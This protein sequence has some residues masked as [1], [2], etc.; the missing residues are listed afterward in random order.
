[1][2]NENDDV[3]TRAAVL[4]SCYDFRESR[5]ELENHGITNIYR[6]LPRI[7]QPALHIAWH[8]RLGFRQVYAI[9]RVDSETWRRLGRITSIRGLVSLPSPPPHPRYI[10]AIALFLGRILYVSWIVPER[11]VDQVHGE[12]VEWAEKNNAVLVGSGLRLP[13]WNCT[14]R[15]GLDSENIEENAKEYRL[16]RNTRLHRSRMPILDYIIVSVLD[17]FPLIT[18]SRLRKVLYAIQA[19]IEEGGREILGAEF[20]GR[21]LYRYY[22]SLSQERIV[23]RIW[24]YKL[25]HPVH[26]RL[27]VA[28]DPGVAET[29]YALVAST[30]SAATILESSQ[31]VILSL[32]AH[33]QAMRQ[34]MEYLGVDVL[35]TFYPLVTTVFPMPYE[36]YH[37][38]EGRW[39]NNII[40]GLFEILAR[41]R[42]IRQA[43]KQ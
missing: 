26:E 40:P 20:K 9:V 12:V 39:M 19:R 35:Y 29:A 43:T 23:G 17:R 38:L 6:L 28:V 32:L 8:T 22:K 13:I 4:F 30:L 34:I 5:R 33:P 1:M 15:L 14:G 16:A 24:A 7:P 42:L 21:Y 2:W 36:L 27:V 18:A 25:I 41:M 3:L 10:K 37:P 11:R 31:A